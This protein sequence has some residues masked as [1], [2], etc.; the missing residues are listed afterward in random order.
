MKQSNQM[1]L[2]KSKY[3]LVIPYKSDDV[4]IVYNTLQDSLTLTRPGLYSIK[5]IT[6]LHTQGILVN[7][8][9]DEV[10]VIRYRMNY[11]KY[12]AHRLHL[13]LT[14]TGICNCD[15]QYCFA[16]DSFP[17]KAM[18]REDISYI[19]DF[20][21]LELK[22]HPIQRINIDFF[23]GEP[24]SCFELCLDIMRRVTKLASRYGITPEFQFYTNGTIQPK[25]GYIALKEFKSTK[26]LITLDGLRNIHDRL[27]PMK[28][29]DSCFDNIIANLKEIQSVG[30]QTV[31]RI[32]FGKRNYAAIPE[33]LDYI[34]DMHMDN[35]PIEFYP[36]QNMSCGSADY[37]EA[38]EMDDLPRLNTFL[39]AAA[40]VRNIKLSARP[41]SACCYCSAFT[42]TMFVIDPELNVYKCALLQ[43]E[44]KHSIG[45]LK[46]NTDL[47]RDSTFYDWLTY[48][49][50][51]EIGCKDCISLPV[52]SGGCGGSG[53][54]RYGTHHHSN[55]Y[56]LSPKMLS[57]KI[58]NYIEDNYSDGLE[59]FSH[60]KQPLFIIE[61]AKYAL[62]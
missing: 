15:C 20:I 41:I 7:S 25:Q 49:P 43:C 61:Q 8:D 30:I 45:N 22:V 3:N 29:G 52:C 50:S 6:A 13:F 19:I 12:A 1:T 11:Q 55:C 56:E 47:Q 40:K 10:M 32:N 21:Q 42:N 60:S 23:G 59:F 36:I 17:H 9:L 2:K 26:L 33:L 62:P 37:A 57:L 51:T 39:Y 54:F 58:L 35:I 46:Q 14:V 34:V 24:F 16:R 27:R 28:S 18:G 53:T 44:R 31:I 38:I 5:D 48:D 4:H